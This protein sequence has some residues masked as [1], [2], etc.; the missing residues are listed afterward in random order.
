MS[1]SELA[2]LR[3]EPSQVWRAGQER[4][5]QMIARW[6]RLEN[7]RVLVAGVGVGMY[8][9][10]FRQRYTPD[11]EAFDIE[12][13]R[14]I[15]ARQNNTPHAVVAA[16]EMLP[17]PTNMKSWSMCRMIARRCVRWFGC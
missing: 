12:Y 15:D 7:T 13:E 9:N 16:A 1:P 5:L 2:A 11:V 10:A 4:R 8:S 6:T 17:Y 14:V 3:G